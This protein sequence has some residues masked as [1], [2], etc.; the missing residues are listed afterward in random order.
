V[1]TPPRGKETKSGRKKKKRQSSPPEA[2]FQEELK[3]EGPIPAELQKEKKEGTRVSEGQTKKEKFPR[4][5]DGPKK[6]KKNNHGP[7]PQLKRISLSL[8]RRKEVAGYAALRRKK[9]KRKK[10][11]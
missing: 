2:P 7:V 4:S 10:G 6:S 1:G 9:K 8:T 11:K 3:K 5:L